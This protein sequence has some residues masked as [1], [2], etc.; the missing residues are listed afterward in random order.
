LYVS[1]HCNN[2]ILTMIFAREDK[3]R[4]RTRHQKWSALMN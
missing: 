2:D 1:L 3:S 4:Q